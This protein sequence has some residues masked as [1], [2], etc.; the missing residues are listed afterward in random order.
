MEVIDDWLENVLKPQMANYAPR[1]IYN[2]DET[3]LFYKTVP[4]RTYAHADEKMFGGGKNKDRLTLLMITN[5]DGSDKRKLTAIGR[6]K[7]P[8]CL[9]KYNMRPEHMQVHWMATKKAW[10]TAAKHH[11][12][13]EQL[14]KDMRRQNHHVLYVCDNA[15]CHAVKEYSNVKML[16]LPPNATSVVQV[17]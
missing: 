4:H 15:A 11:E 6:A 2:A 14:N 16:M 5:M 9:K 12:A 8:R 3:A 17:K 13:V 1:D 7:N 10:M